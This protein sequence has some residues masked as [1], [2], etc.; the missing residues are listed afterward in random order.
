M[1]DLGAVLETYL[2]PATPG[3]LIEIDRDDAAALAAELR[4]ARKVVAAACGC[5]DLLGPGVFDAELIDATKAHLILMLA[6]YD[7]TV[8]Q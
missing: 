4:A 8:G 1:I 5:P 6:A 2:E 3:V 7:N